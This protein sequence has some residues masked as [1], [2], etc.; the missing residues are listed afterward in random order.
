MASNENNA[1]LLISQ[2]LLFYFLYFLTIEL[3]LAEYLNLYDNKLTGTIPTNLKLQDLYY[4]DIGRN[5]IGGS[6]PED[7]GTDFV[8]LRYFHVDHNR[9]TE[10]IPDTIPPMASGRLISFLANHNRLEGVVPDNWTMFHKLVQYTL[11]GMY[12]I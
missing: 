9:L 3:I 2:I 12:I 8:E 6:I 4:F 5:F 7:V 10:R 11:H 1:C